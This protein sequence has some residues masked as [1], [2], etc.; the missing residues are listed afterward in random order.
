MSEVAMQRRTSR[1]PRYLRLTALCVVAGFP[2]IAC[3]GP[4]PEPPDPTPAAPSDV[5]ATPGPGYVTV[6]W[7]DNSGNETGFEVYRSSPAQ[8]TSQ[9]SGDSSVRPASGGFTAQQD[10]EPLATLP[11]DTTSYVDLDVELDT[12]YGYQ[13]VAV[14]EDGSSGAA[15]TTSSA[16][17]QP[18]AD[19]MVGTVDRVYT[20]EATG[21]VFIVYMMF[22]E[23]VL[24]DEEIG[25][26]FTIT[27]PPGWNE[28]Q[29]F[30]VTLAPDSSAFD[31]GFFRINLHSVDS[32]AGTYTLALV[33]DG[34]TYEATADL[35]DITYRVGRPSDIDVSVSADESAITA[36]WTS[37]SD[38]VTTYT[39]IH[40]ANWGAMLLRGPVEGTTKTYSGLDLADGQY[41]FD[42]MNVNVD[43][44]GYPV[45]V[46]HFG[47]SGMYAPFGIGDPQSDLCDSPEQLIEIPDLALRDAVLNALYRDPGDIKC[48]DMVLLERL[49]AENAGIESIEGLQYAVNLKSVELGNENEVTSIEALSGLDSLE[50]V[51]FWGSPVSDASPLA[52]KTSLLGIDLGGTDITDLSFLEGL[53]NLETLMLWNLYGVDVTPVHDLAQLRWLSLS[54]MGLK[55]ADAAFLEDMTSLEILWFEW[56]ELT[57]LAPL[58]ANPGLGE[59]DEVWVHNNFLDLDDPDVMDDVQTLLDRG[60]DLHYEEQEALP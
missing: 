5:T 52:G 35:T 18:G 24:L 37:P 16:S 11:P 26:Q 23:S 39:S 20:E 4:P 55:D 13:V 32:V 50:H 12:E 34:A 49:W 10:D 3:S 29:P 6:A 45:K 56:N 57:S 38:A 47:Q 19:L 51:S 48:I 17:V 27:G 58:V 7:K 33:I 36:S 59:G 2:I 14:G 22:D 44:L 40:T 30:E 42:V 60:V 15:P 41:L 54:G 28:D 43:L 25:A 1:V 21:T 31:D 9:S 53:A 46:E 8:A